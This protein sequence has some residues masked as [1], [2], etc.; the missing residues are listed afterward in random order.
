METAEIA[1]AAIGRALDRDDL[2]L[3]HHLPLEIER[4]LK[5]RYLGYQRAESWMSHPWVADQLSRLARRRPIIRR[6]AAGILNETVDPR[7]VF[8]LRG[9]LTALFR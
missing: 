6:A 5:P 3:L 2:S 9:L 1:A 7:A 8:S 4:A